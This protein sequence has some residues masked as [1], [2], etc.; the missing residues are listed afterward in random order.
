MSRGKAGFAQGEPADANLRYVIPVRRFVSTAVL[1]L[2][3]TASAGAQL[4]FQVLK[5]PEIKKRLESYQGDDLKREATLKSFFEAAGCPQLTEMPV[6]HLKEPDVICTLAGATESHILVTAH[7]DHVTE[8]DG[9]V[10]NWSG[11]SL[12]PSLLEAVKLRKPQHTFVFIGFSG[13]EQGLLGSDFYAKS[14]TVAERRQ[15]AAVVNMDTL[16]LGPTEVWVNR[17]DKELTEMLNAVAHGMNLPL[18]GMNVDQV[19]YSDEES[20][21]KY[22][23]PTVTIHSLTQDTLPILHSSRDRISAIHFDDYYNTY[24]LVTGYLLF[25]DQGLKS[26]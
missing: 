17:S 20:F 10:D 7:Y 8:G 24:R 16:G 5:G 11:A 15:I 25:I 13:E 6:K 3:L 23:I 21:R 2:L 26:Q 12:L 1:T 22:K 14:L 18:S 4:Q 9:V 19:G